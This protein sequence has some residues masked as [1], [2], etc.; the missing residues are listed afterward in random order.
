MVRVRPLRADSGLITG[1]EFDT[2]GL[3]GINTLVVD[4]NP[5]MEQLEQH[6]FNNI[7]Q[8]TFVVEGDKVK[9]ILD[10]TFDGLHILD[11]DIVS[12]KP[13]IAIQLSD[14]N[15]FLVLDDTSDFRIFITDVNGI[16]RQAFFTNMNRLYDM[17]F[18][19]AKKG[20]NKA[21]VIFKPQLLADGVYQLRVSATDRSKNESGEIDYQISFE[22]INKSTIT[23]L[24]NYP[25]PFSTSTRFVFVLTGSKVPDNLQI[26]IMT[27]S[28]KLIKTIDSHEI[29][30]I[31]IGRNVSEYAWDGKDEYGDKLANGI[32]LY[33][34]NT[35]L[36]G[37]SIEH[38]STSADKYFKKGFG[39]M[40]I[41][42]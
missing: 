36:D 6:L 26:Q 12:S 11:G 37:F 40:V 38:R 16:E 27:I 31:H 3:A 33:R 8:L 29:G 1:V 30:P 18:I 17:V 10:V 23:N 24:L 2:K 32:Y 9:P 21:Q 28:G 34:V 13:E 25:N 7:G 5:G 35:K 20:S 19:P 22:V 15:P 42:R 41:L 14:E 39:K 4:V